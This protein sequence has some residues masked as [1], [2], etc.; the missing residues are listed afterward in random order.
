L[1]GLNGIAY[2]AKSGLKQKLW[3]QSKYNKFS[4]NDLT[5]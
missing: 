5:E 4:I 3:N 2:Q 1:L